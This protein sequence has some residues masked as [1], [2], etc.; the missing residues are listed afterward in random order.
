[1][2][3]HSATPQRSSKKTLTP[4]LAVPFAGLL[5]LGACATAN[6]PESPPDDEEVPP[7]LDDVPFQV[8]DVS[9]GGDE[10]P[11]AAIDYAL[12]RKAA[13]VSN[14]DGD[15]FD[16][17]KTHL[18]K[19]GLR[20]VRLQQK[21]RG[22]EVYSADVVVHASDSHILSM[23]GHM[24]FG[25]GS[26]DIATSVDAKA[27]MATAK[28]DYA[29]A[30]KG[31]TEVP[32]AYSRETSKLVILPLSKRGM[33][34]VWHVEFFTEL[35]DGV[36]PGLW[37]YFVDAKDGSIVDNFNAIH[38]LSQ[39]SG[40]GG[41]PK[42]PR[43]WTDALDV[44]PSGNQF[45]ADTARVQTVDMNNSQSGSGTIVTGPLNNFGDAAINDAHGFAEVTLNMMQEWMGRSSIDDNG[46]VIRSRVHYGLNFENAFWDGT[47]MTYGDGANTFYALSGDVDV[48]GHE[49]N[50]GFTSN[51]SDLIYANQSGG[52]NEGFS[53]IAGTVAEFYDE[54]AGAD[55]DVGR[56]IF[57]GDSALR[58]MCD[59]TADGIS[60]DHASDYT[61]GLDPHFSSGVPNKAFCLVSKRLAGGG[62]NG[63]ATQA[64]VRRAGEAFYEANAS[65]WTTG[66]TYVQGCEGVMN[67]ANAL[68]FDSSELAALAD[69]WA[70]V[71]VD[72]GGGP[73]NQAPSVAITSPASGSS[74]SGDVNVTATASDPDG[75]VAEVIFTLPDGSVVSDT[76]A[77]YATTW[78]STSVA[79][80]N[81][82]ITARAVDDEGQG[83]TT[84][85]RTVSVNNGGG[86]DCATGN[87]AA[88]DVPISIPDNNAGG[89][90]SNIDVN[91][92]GTVASVSVSLG[93]THTWRGDLIVTLVGPSG[94]E[95]VLHSRTG[96]SADNLVITDLDVAAFVGQAAGGTW[97]L[98]VAD[99]AGQDLG[100]LDSFS[101][102]VV[103][104]CDGG[105][106]D[107]WSA[108]DAPNLAIVDNG[109]ACTSVSV[110]DS[111]DAASV[112][113]DLA[114]V[115]DW[116]SILRATLEHNGTTQTVFGTG[117]FPRNSGSFALTDE[118]VSGFS[119]DA[120][121][122]W[123]LC[124]IDTDAFN[125]TGTLQ[126]W[127]VHN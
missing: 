81:A 32:L 114:G 97:S 46:F 2:S 84:V 103:A 63:T 59:P 12:E 105:G 75:D 23:S 116:R 9:L 72:C 62:P 111:G 10:L 31:M 11:G 27:A 22:I 48:V 68:G 20:H 98:R 41:N 6:G 74:V 7:R 47:Q 57:Q 94:T 71:G 112:N 119:G 86:G 107:D 93:I 92:S 104:N 4:F 91:G 126:T 8:A 51:H 15:D 5:A 69:S 54:G 3:K 40:P 67:A 122:T 21:H 29:T 102:D 18:G 108:S 17:I 55:F 65:Y 124:I 70:D 37:N 56:D 45:A 36:R 26:L 13:M 78:D 85:S 109:T 33:R 24:G 50:H 35:Q 101:V 39:A 110:A 14:I 49:I 99:R 87:H 83:S 117:T 38:T 58:F 61:A 118:A 16:V 28:T 88:S 19:D 52:L 120:S 25:L 106:N 89:I 100:T 95:S 64:S 53:D 44:E 96:G 34:V 127:S 115:H 80:G 76:S 82:T 60:I 123:T 43:T 30:A 73:G 42:T 79:N 90:T 77:P 113:V 66:T 121:G 125:D 1:M